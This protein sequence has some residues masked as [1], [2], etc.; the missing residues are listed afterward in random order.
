MHAYSC[1]VGQHDRVVI[2]LCLPVSQ[3]DTSKW[4][5]DKECRELKLGLRLKYRISY[6]LTVSSLVFDQV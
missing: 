2:V 6:S 1:L 4:T 3:D 5:V